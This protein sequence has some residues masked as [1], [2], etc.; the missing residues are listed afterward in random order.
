VR[1]TRAYLAGLGTAGSIVVGAA[2]IF[3]LASAIVAFHG[4]P[5]ADG[6]GTPAQIVL[7]APARSETLVA[8]RLAVLVG[9]SRAA[10][11]RSAPRT[12]VGAVVNTRRPSGVAAGGAGSATLTIGGP[13]TTQ[14]TQP[15]PTAGPTRP[16]TRTSP[17]RTSTSPPSPTK[18]PTPPTSGGGTGGPGAAGTVLKKVTGPVGGTVSGTGSGVGT[19]VKKV[20]APAG[21]PI[22]SVGSGAGDTITKVTGGAGDVISKTGSGLG[23]AA[24]NV[25]GSVGGLLSAS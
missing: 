4:W 1:A 11:V 17:T 24:G 14:P 20:T 18:P 19:I 13:P 16:P 23:S 5:N 21:G 8:R 2:L 10:G 6:L 25:T 9:T 15:A 7:S 3:V 22:S 12:P